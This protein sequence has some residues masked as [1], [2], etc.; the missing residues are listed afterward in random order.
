MSLD[1]RIIREQLQSCISQRDQSAQTFQQC[2]GAIAVL[3]E[4]LKVCVMEEI[5]RAEEQAKL[6]EEK[7]KAEQQKALEAGDAAVMDGLPEGEP[8]GK[9]IEQEPVETPQE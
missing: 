9:A 2:V 8:N 7:L 3:E 6:D 4:Q 5:K 1:M